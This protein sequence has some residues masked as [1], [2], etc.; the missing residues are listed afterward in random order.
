MELHEKFKLRD[1]IERKATAVKDGEKLHIDKDVLEQV[2]FDTYEV[3]IDR[4]DLDNSEKKKAKFVTWSGSFLSKID[5]SEVSFEDVIWDSNIKSYFKDK[6]DIDS[7]MKINLS[8]TNAKIDFSKSFSSKYNDRL[9]INGCIFS[10]TDLSNN[11]LENVNIYYS[12]LS[13]TNINIDFNSILYRNLIVETNLSNNDFGNLNSGIPYLNT[14]PIL[15]FESI[16][17]TS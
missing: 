11:K 8:N 6:K 12:D 5:L 1:E 9:F 14:P 17:V 7:G 13:N 15:S 4:N 10:G 2:L 3:A 16:I